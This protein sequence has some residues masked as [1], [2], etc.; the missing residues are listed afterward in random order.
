VRTLINIEIIIIVLVVV[1][2]L[3]FIMSL[4][5]KHG[6]TQVDYD[7]TPIYFS[8]SWIV[9]RNT[10]ARVKIASRMESS[11]RREERNLSFL[12]APVLPSRVVIFTRAHTFRSLNNSWTN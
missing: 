11:T 9:A 3:E 10:R 7:L 4:R 1:P 8:P 12:C 6:R 5:S 2:F